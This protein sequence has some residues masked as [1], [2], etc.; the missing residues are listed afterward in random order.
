MF[1]AALTLLLFVGGCGPAKVWIKPSPAIDRY[2]I[3]SLVVMPFDRVETP[4]LVEQSLTPDFLV[5][6]GAKRSDIN[7]AVPPPSPEKLIGTASTVPEDVPRRVTEIIYQ[8][9]RQHAGLE[10]HGPAEG[11]RALQ[12]S[13]IQPDA[14]QEE[15]AREVARQ[16]GVDAVLF[17]RVSI[18]KERQGSRIAADSAAVGFEVKLLAADGVPLWAGSYYEK[19]RPM[20]EDVVGFVQRRGMFVTA[21]ELAHYGAEKMMRRFPFG[22]RTS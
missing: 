22:G 2:Q 7:I 18:Y 5:P 16:L 21:E 1:Y 13:D 20:T 4:Q 17:G 10:V 19:Q 14:P 9:L 15:R 11:Q 12:Q 8:Q 3:R 6:R